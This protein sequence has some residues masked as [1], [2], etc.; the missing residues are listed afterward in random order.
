[1][2]I[3]AALAVSAVELLTVI[4][5]VHH[6]LLMPNKNLATFKKVVIRGDLEGS[7]IRLDGEHHERVALAQSMELDDLE[8]DDEHE[9]HRRPSLNATGQHGRHQH[10]RSKSDSRE[11]LFSASWGVLSENTSPAGNQF[12]IDDDSDEAATPVDTTD[13][14]SRHAKHVRI[15]ERS[16]RMS[17]ASDSSTLRGSSSPSGSD[18]DVRKYSPEDY[19]REVATG[20]GIEDFSGKRP[21]TASERFTSAAKYFV[22]FLSRGLVIWAY[23]VSLF[24]IC[25]YTGMGRQYYL[26]SLLAHFIKGS[27]FFWFGLLTFGRF[28]GAWAEY[29]WAWNARPSS[30]RNSK[31][32]SGEFVECFVIFLYGI[33]NV[34]LERIGAAHSDPYTIKQVQHIS[35]AGMFWFAGMAGMA[36]E[37]STIKTLL[38]AT[39]VNLNSR[40][41]HKAKAKEPITYAASFNPFPALVIGVVSGYLICSNLRKSS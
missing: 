39:V 34:W 16:P 15:A 13:P 28:L 31:V 10:R 35:I 23:I 37:S 2:L 4:A 12:V 36:L 11:V 24:G 9:R 40:S 17:V 5:H 1:M 14:V 8:A 29:G 22:Y 20:N 19:R 30:K 18:H 27:I 33:S 32:P 3:F 26:P 7:D 6:F 25:V 21:R 41:A 38:A